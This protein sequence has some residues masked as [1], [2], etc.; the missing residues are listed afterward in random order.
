MKKPRTYFQE[1]MIRLRKNNFDNDIARIVNAPDRYGVDKGPIRI[2]TQ[3]IL[4]SLV[5]GIIETG[6]MLDELAN[7]VNARIDDL[8]KEVALL[9]EK[10]VTMEKKAAAK[11][12]T[13][14]TAPK[15]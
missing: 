15:E 5:E 9:K 13:K 6:K 14:K 3:P 4:G 1:I 8:E 12:P 11:P 10:V 2:G 7:D